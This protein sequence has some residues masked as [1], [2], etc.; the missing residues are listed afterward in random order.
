MKASNDRFNIVV[1]NEGKHATKTW[2]W[3]P[4]AIDVTINGSPQ[5]RFEHLG[6]ETGSKL[7]AR[8]DGNSE[9]ISQ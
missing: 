6:V 9:I 4:C 3:D 7:H 5:G 1:L 8:H 2:N